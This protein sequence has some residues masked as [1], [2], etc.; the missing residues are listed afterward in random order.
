M[1][2]ARNPRAEERTLTNIFKSQ[3][4]D[5]TPGKKGFINRSGVISI[6]HFHRFWSTWSPSY[7]PGKAAWTAVCSASHLLKGLEGRTASARHSLWTTG[8]ENPHQE[9]TRSLDCKWLCIFLLGDIGICGNWCQTEPFLLFSATLQLWFWLRYKV[10]NYFISKS[11]SSWDDVSWLQSMQYTAEELQAYWKKN[12]DILHFVNQF[13]IGNVLIAINLKIFF[14]P[15]PPLTTHL[16]DRPPPCLPPLA[17]IL[18]VE[19]G[20][21]TGLAEGVYKALCVHR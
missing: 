21:E 20:P 8:L 15:P 10:A 5:E 19:Q 17:Q 9:G 18:M 14:F 11:I 12:I 6:S 3:F 13:I 7:P 16:W 4:S 2:A 1:T